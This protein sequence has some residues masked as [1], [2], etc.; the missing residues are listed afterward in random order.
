[1]QYAL[2][3]RHP[4]GVTPRVPGERSETRD[5]VATRYPGSNPIFLM[6]GSA[7]SDERNF[8]SAAAACRS[9]A[10]AGVAVA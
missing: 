1:V 10:L 6:M 5:P 3:R 8:T 9:L 2:A 4:F 7:G